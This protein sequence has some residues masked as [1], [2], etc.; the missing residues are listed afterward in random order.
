[1][2]SS[3]EP[4]ER[5]Y[6]VA[7]EATRRRRR[8][9]L[10]LWPDDAWRHRLEHDLRK[11]VR[12]TGGA[13]VPARNLHMTLVF[14]GSVDEE[15]LAAARAAAQVIARP[16][17][18][19]LLGRVEVWPRQ[20]LLC[21]VPSVKSEPLRELAIDLRT[22]LETRGFEVEKRPFRA[23]VTLARK[24]NRPRSVEVLA[25][26]TWPVRDFALVES[27]TASGGSE[28][29]VLERWALRPP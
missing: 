18:D 5:P 24:V 22:Q 26:P 20:H 14:L 15:R 28:Y 11:S 9:F 13:A 21:L 29:R 19:L 2:S 4:D 23:H 6:E 1:M 16:A 7:V 3:S 8:L 10:A 25:L 12:R 27:E 17:F